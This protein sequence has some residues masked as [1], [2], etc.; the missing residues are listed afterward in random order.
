MRLRS[1]PVVVALAAGVVAAAFGAINAHAAPAPA[2]G[3]LVAKYGF[4]G[5]RIASVLDES[6]GGHNLT[7]VSSHAGRLRRIAHGSGQAFAFPAPCTGKAA[8]DCPRVAL[9]SPS[10]AD[11]N[12]GTADLA[13]GAALELGAAQTS[14]GQNVVQKGYSATGSQYK[15][16]VDGRAGHPSCVVV[17]DRTPAIQLVRSSVTVADGD[18]HAVEC[19]RVA[20]ELSILVDGRLRGVKAIPADLSISNDEPLAIGAK[21]AYRDN[22]QFRGALDDV[23]VRI[24]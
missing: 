15:L 5:R 24:G 12:P 16:Q 19:R 17:D 9:R 4:D 2:G 23:W 14:K 6:G 8:P 11:L 13:Y 3:R 1:R 7:V 22:D 18:W 20:D 10:S 21:G